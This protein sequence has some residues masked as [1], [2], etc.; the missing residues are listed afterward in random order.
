MDG[1]IWTDTNY[2]LNLWQSHNMIV[3]G[4]VVARWTAG[5]QVERSILCRGMI[6]KQNSSH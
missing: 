5:Q 1:A 4:R 2:I 6:N 3:Y